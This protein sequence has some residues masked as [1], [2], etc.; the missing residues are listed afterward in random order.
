MQ[1]FWTVHVKF[2][3]EIKNIYPGKT[4]PFLFTFHHS[5]RWILRA[6]SKFW[7]LYEAFGRQSWTYQFY[8]AEPTHPQGGDDLQILQLDVG[9][10][11]VR[12]IPDRGQQNVRAITPTGSRNN[13]KKDLRHHSAKPTFIIVSLTVVNKHFNITRSGFN[14]T[15]RRKPEGKCIRTTVLSWT[16]LLQT[17]RVIWTKW[18][19]TIREDKVWWNSGSLHQ[20]L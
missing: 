4:S 2:A 3:S 12:F 6:L 9:E 5:L 8:T 7:P 1:T 11:L 19:S 14:E 16:V 18:M 13:T 20:C 17:P 10:L 15:Q